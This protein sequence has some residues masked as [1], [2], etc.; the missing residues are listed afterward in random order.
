MIRLIALLFILFT[1]PILAQNFDAGFIGG[2]TAS[3]ISGDGLAGFDKGGARFG[4][5]ISYPLKK[6]MNFQVEMQYIQKG[7]KSPS[8]KEGFSNYTMNLHYLELPFTLNY[9][10]K[11]GIVLESG[12]GPGILFAY[13]EKD[14]IGELGGIS[15][16]IFA[17]DFLCGLH[18]QFL[19]NLK[20][21]VRYG[22]SLLP[23]RGKSNISDSE[24]NKEW[25]SSSVSF[26]LMY[27]I[28]R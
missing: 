4:A 11:D 28:S 22:N 6:K 3:Q 10:L 15:P 9:K 25:Y 19:D 1:S 14:E 21:G 26:A 18:Y 5:Y 7:S 17:L 13:S 23:I 12:L 16:S 27:Q 2:F 8:G 24:K 20:I